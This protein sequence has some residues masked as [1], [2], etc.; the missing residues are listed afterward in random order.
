[1]P[2]FSFCA[3]VLQHCAKHAMSPFGMAIMAG[4][5]LAVRKNIWFT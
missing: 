3:K 2:L 4:A 5:M 1:M